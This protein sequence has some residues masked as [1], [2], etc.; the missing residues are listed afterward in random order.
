MRNLLLAGACAVAVF[1]ARTA[2]AQIVCSN[3][4]TELM[5]VPR[6]V[7]RV[8]QVVDQIATLKSQ[9]QQ[10]ENVYASVA[11]MPDAAL[12]QLG[13]QLN[14]DR[15][16][17]P[18]PTTSGALGGML[19]GSLLGN[20]TGLGQQ[21][22]NQ[23]R[24]YTPS[25]NDYAAN[26]MAT[27]AAS[28][29]NVQAMSDQLYQSAA[30]HTT[31][32]QGL[33][34]QLA[35]APDDKAVA[36]ISARVQLEQTYI[37]GQ[38]VQAQAISTMQAAQVRNAD[39]QSSESR[40][41]YIE[42]AIRHLETGTDGSTGNDPC[43][44]PAAGQSQGGSGGLSADKTGLSGGMVASG[45]D[46]YLGQAVGTGQCVALVQAADPGIGPTRNWAEGATVQGN[47][48]LPVGTAIATFDG[49]GRYANALDGSSHAA[50]YL[51]QNAQGLIVE[52]QWAGQVAHQRVIPWSGNNASNSGSAFRVITQPA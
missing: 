16:R 25:A 6:E 47:A 27:N 12:S 31:T 28:I 1:Y 52:D 42:A 37:A 41:C 23:N 15:F 35:S 24:I 8:K 13:Q 45:Y 19:N 38:Q 43:A 21:Y 46:Q 4:T 48:G 9:L 17:N 14:V 34:S 40:R 2:R 22:L 49:S 18:L 44:R 51:G 10:I 50:I 26:A 11:H 5:E 30:A 39:Q 36:D 33:E 3:C 32:L 20:L 29:A 7:A